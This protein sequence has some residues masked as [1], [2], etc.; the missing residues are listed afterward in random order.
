[1][2]DR[3]G[4]HG[5]ANGERQRP[6]SGATLPWRRSHPGSLDTGGRTTGMDETALPKG[7]GHET[8]L[9]VVAGWHTA[10]A[11]EAPALTADVADETGIADAVGRQTRFLESEGQRHRLTDAGAPLAAALDDGRGAE[12]RTHARDLFEAWPFTDRVVGLVRGNPL[13]E[14]ALVRQVLALAGLDPERSRHRTG[15][16]ALVETLAWAGLLDWT[17]EGYAPGPATGTDEPSE[18]LSLTLELGVDVDPE[19]VESL[20]A[21]LRAGLLDGDGPDSVPRVEATIETDE[22]SGAED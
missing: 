16:R 17:P 21:S 7:V 11:A 15:G 1:M 9:D 2:A 18:A 4:G 3:E 12:A 8:L 10:G 5:N 20:V 6:V 22:A 19:M 14:D 13:P